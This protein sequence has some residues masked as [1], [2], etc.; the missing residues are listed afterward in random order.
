M[1]EE[2][3]QAGGVFTK[4]FHMLCVLTDTAEHA[5]GAASESPPVLYAV[6]WGFKNCWPC[7][8][9]ISVQPEMI[10]LPYSLVET[11][12]ACANIMYLT[13]PG[14]YGMKTVNMTLGPSLFSRKETNLRS[15]KAVWKSCSKA[16][17]L[18]LEVSSKNT[19]V[20]NN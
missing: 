17:P 11:A 15:L 6:T 14:F 19:P 10:L 18:I 8:L 12:F 9:A 13:F 7:S 2:G 16:N 20:L 3:P 1:A 5:A 4:V